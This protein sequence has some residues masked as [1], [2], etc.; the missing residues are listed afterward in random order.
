MPDY[1]TAEHEP[2][3]RKRLGEA[4]RHTPNS[5]ILFDEL[6]KAHPTVLDSLLAI[7][8]EGTCNIRDREP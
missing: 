7:L 5:I 8:D 4:V 3:F 6:E 2:G 1:K